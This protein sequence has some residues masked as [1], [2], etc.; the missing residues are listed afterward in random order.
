MAKTLIEEIDE[1]ERDL[2]SRLQKVRELRAETAGEAVLTKNVVPLA[3]F[4]N[5]RNT[6]FEWLI[7]GSLAMGSVAM[8]AADPAMGKT[9]L[10]V[11]IA[12]CLAAGRDPF[13]EAHVPRPIECLYIAAEGSRG[14]FQNRVM[15]ARET[16]NIPMSAGWFIQAGGN[17]DYKIGSSGL[18]GMIEKTK[19]QFVVLDTIGYFWNGDENNAVEWKQRVMVPLR[20]LTSAYGCTFLL[21]HHFVKQSEERKGWQRARGTS[22]MFADLDAFYQLEPGTVGDPSQEEPG[23][24]RRILTQAKNKY[25]LTRQWGL[26]FNASQARFG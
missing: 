21:V 12:L 19:A 7:G 6:D 2:E 13:Y 16:L 9:T 4:I 17:T 18:E 8:L 5:E 25:G 15:K 1:T 14:A 20:K 3:D 22:A 24:E 11:Q 23:V 10:L 26:R